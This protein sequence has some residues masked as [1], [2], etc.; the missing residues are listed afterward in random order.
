MPSLVSRLNFSHSIYCTEFV[1]CSSNLDKES[2]FNSFSPY[3]LS[4]SPFSGQPHLLLSPFSGQPHL[5]LSPF[6]GQPHLLLS[7]FSGQP[8]LFAISLFRSTSCLC[9][10]SFLVNSISESYTHRFHITTLIQVYI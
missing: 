1:L 4:L 6:S 7:P 8:H 2:N 3:L 5:L 10:L 9:Y